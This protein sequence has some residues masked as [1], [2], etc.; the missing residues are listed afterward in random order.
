MNAVEVAANPFPGLRPYRPSESD[1]FFGRDE[2]IDELLVRLNQSRFVAV[3]GTS[4]SGKSSLVLAGLIPAIERGYLTG[5]GAGWRVAIMRPGGDPMGELARNIATSM[6]IP[7]ADAQGE[8]GRSSLGLAELAKASLRPGENLLLVVDQFEELFRYHKNAASREEREASAGFVKLLLA[9]TGRSDVP[10]AGLDQV[11]VFVILTMRSDYLGKSS[12][13]RGLPEALNGSQYLVPRLSRDQMREGIEGPV[14]MAGA[15]ITPE[16]VQRL[17]NDT[18]DNP[19]QLP[20]LQHLLMRLWEVSAPDRELGEPIDLKH[21]EDEGVG[22]MSK[23]LSLDA[24]R[25]FAAAAGDPHKEEIV[26]RVF[27]RLVESGA[28]NEESRRPSR[29]SELA[30]VCAAS[31]VEVAGAVEPFRQRGFV[32]FSSEKDPIVDISHESLIRLW[33]KLKGWVKEENGSA[34]T[35]SRLADWVSADYGPYSGLALDQALLW[36]ETAKP[37]DAWAQRYRPGADTFRNAMEFL[38]RSVKDRE[39]GMERQA[40]EA[41]AQQDAQRRQK[42][43]RRTR[44]AAAIIWA[45]FLLAVVLAVYAVAQQRAAEEERQ[46]AIGESA[47]ALR[48][49]GLAESATV[50]ANKQKGLAEDQET[51][52]DVARGEAE[53]Q[54]VAATSGR[55]AVAA[56]LNKSA[57]LD[58]AALLSIEGDRTADSFEARNSLLASIQAGQGIISFLH[59]PAAVWSAAISPDGKLIASAGGDNMVRIWDVSRHK[60]LGD[61]LKGHIGRVNSVAFSPDGKLLASAGGDA[62]VRLWNVASRRPASGPLEGHSDTVYRA[63]FSPD[64][65]LLA[66]ASADQTV[67]LWDVA[68]GRSLVEPLPGRFGIVFSVAFSPDGKLLACA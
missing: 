27:Q 68:G 36:M 13:F 51:L 18:G 32:F 34:A 35:Y 1:L 33:D 64:G 67:R 31:E 61:P 57:H 48:Q 38:G 10:V 28:E 21:Y 5:A 66:S 20:V 54:A 37:N 63:V 47:E 17:L 22:G 7:E 58:L 26:R 39:E 3:V 6:G 55:L 19:D 44:I 42:D 53:K 14:G 11:P 24:D 25:A 41:A 29:L 12:Q 23:A 15:R 30:A 46:K 50:E 8:L 45:M 9:A 16:L 43:L 2:Q 56:L 60:Q 65:K 59:H 62:T 49:K 4:G 52:A 40:R